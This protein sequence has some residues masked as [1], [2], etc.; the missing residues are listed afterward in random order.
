MWVKPGTE[1]WHAETFGSRPHGRA[2]RIGSP[3][4]SPG[5]RVHT[6]ATARC[7][8]GP[9]SAPEPGVGPASSAGQRQARRAREPAA[10]GRC[11]AATS[12]GS[13]RAEPVPVGGARE[14]ALRCALT[15]AR[16]GG[17]QLPG[18]GE[19]RARKSRCPAHARPWQML[20]LAGESLRADTT[21]TGSPWGAQAEVAPLPALSHGVPVP[22]TE[23]EPPPGRCR[24]AC[25]A[26]SAPERHLPGDQA[27]LCHR[28]CPSHVP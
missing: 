5:P 1:G 22:G 27:G 24:S 12:S 19:P 15:A 28:L 17:S 6:V 21:P 10:R 14:A 25:A 3:V 4:P 8:P 2:G 9:F 26:R 11:L 20:P 7:G 23:G 16:H 13:R 18:P